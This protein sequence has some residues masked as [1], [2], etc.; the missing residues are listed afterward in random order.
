MGRTWPSLAIAAILLLCGALVHPA[1]GQHLSGPGRPADELLATPAVSG[2]EQELASRIRERV[3]KL[4]PITDNVGNIYVTI[5]SG[6]PR[7]LIVTS[8]DE[9]GYVVSEITADGYLR[10]QRL[11]Q[12]APNAVF[13][14]LHAAQPVWVGTRGGKKVVG[15][16]TGLSVHLQPGRQNPPTMSHPDEMYVDVGA[17]S[18][19]EVRKAGIDV[20]DP[21][22]LMRTP[23]QFG[24]D[25]I[26]AP[27]IGD[28]I[29]CVVLADLLRAFQERKGNLTGTLTVAFVAQ[30]WTGGRGLDRLLNELHPD[31]MIYV[32][33]LMPAK[34]DEAKQNAGPAP[35]MPKPGGGLL[36][37][38]TGRFSR[39][40]R[41]G[42]GPKEH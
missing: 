24:A 37:C 8:M 14:L 30:Q 17:M 40:E 16:F 9:P 5:G 28:H 41:F 10:V 13:D 12:R 31:E 23:Q 7:R 6:T 21:I 18:V 38:D 1:L 2:Y 39:A 20:L 19:A 22:S 34:T 29:G 36:D 25:E 27:A 3:K 15:V 33:R 35:A 42:S 11:P 26:T 4:S 32:G